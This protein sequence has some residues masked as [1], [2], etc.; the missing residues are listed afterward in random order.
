MLLEGLGNG[1]SKGV[2]ADIR[3]VRSCGKDAVDRVGIVD[4]NN[5]DNA[6]AVAFECNPRDDLL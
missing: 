4:C 6:R 2:E 1:G 5:N 3:G